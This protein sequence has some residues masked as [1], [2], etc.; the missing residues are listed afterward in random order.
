MNGHEQGNSRA[1]PSRLRIVVDTDMGVDDAAAVAWLLSQRE[2]PVELAGVAAVWGN[3]GVDAA[4]VNV[5]ALLRALGRE[6]VPV[7]MGEAAPSSGPMSPIGSL[8]HGADGMWGRAAGTIATCPKDL[9]AFYRAVAAADTTLLALGPLTNLTRVAALAP[10]VLRRFARIVV[11][12]GAWRHGS[13]TP[14]SETNFWHDPEAADR[15]LAERLPIVLVTRDAHRAFALTHDDLAA[16]ATAGSPAARYLAAPMRAYAQVTGRFGEPLNFPDV[17]AAVL[18]VEPAA[19]TVR[20]SALVRV[21]TGTH[22]LVRGQSV[23][24]FAD[25]ERLAMIEGGAAL[26]RLVE[27][28]LAEPTLHLGRALAAILAREPDNA[29]VV[30]AVDAARVRRSFLCALTREART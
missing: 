7:V 4:A 27:Q 25:N 26:A 22:G 6:Q 19:A 11:L 1:A 28:A 14:V 21:V 24:G 23:M 10:D 17:V 2:R 13:I 3:T 18:A 16:L 15:V 29:E 8:V 30:L 5:V 20:R 9:V 12:G